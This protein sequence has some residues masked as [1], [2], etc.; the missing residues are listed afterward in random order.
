MYSFYARRSQK[1]KNSVKSSV[2][3]FMLLGAKA[4]RR[5]LMKLTPGV[6][7]SAKIVLFCWAIVSC[8][9]RVRRCNW[10]SRWRKTWNYNKLNQFLKFFVVFISKV[11]LGQGWAK[12]QILSA[13]CLL[14]GPRA[15]KIFLLNQQVFHLKMFSK[16]WPEG[17]KF[18]Y[19]GHPLVYGI[20]IV[21]FEIKNV[22]R[23]CL[24]I[25]T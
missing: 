21:H 4:A 12:C 7:E 20:I 15:E 13:G 5:M 25:I 8:N 14:S 3:I 24:E 10:F 22:R 16:V 1:R 2:Y 6:G 17:P 19:N 18:F 9:S 23:F 11:K